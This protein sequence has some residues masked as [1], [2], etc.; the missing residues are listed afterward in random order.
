MPVN[1]TLTPREA[2]CIANNSYFT[3]EGWIKA[4]PSIGVEQWPVVKDAVLGS[5]ASTQTYNGAPANTSLRQTGLK[6]ANLQRVFTATTGAGT[7]TGF[8]YVLRFTQG[9]RKHVVIATRGTRAEIGPADLLTDAYAALTGF[10]DYGVVH[11]GFM[12]TFTSV[13]AGLA[14]DSKL[15]LDADV[16]HCVGHSLGGAVATLVAAHYRTVGQT[17]KLYTFGSPRVGAYGAYAA[18]QQRIGKENI[19]RVSHDL[20]PIS[21][22]GP[23]PYIHV[24]PA[25]TDEN[26]MTLVSP[27]GKLLSVANH[28]MLEYLNS[29]GSSA[30]SWQYVRAQ[31]G[32]VDH[33]NTVLGRWLL[34]NE[35]DRT[36]LRRGAAYALGLLLKLFANEMK[37][38]AN[39]AVLSLTA[40]DMMAELIA[41]GMARIQAISP[42]VFGLM[43]DFAQFAGVAMKAGAE[44]T[45]AI[46][47]RILQTML[48]TLM[49]IA[50]TAAIQAGRGLLPLPLVIAGASALAG[51]VIN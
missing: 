17:V 24:N 22:V 35:A 32:R 37:A 10:G 43:R 18:M 31:T 12:N 40:I 21:L 27:T 50:R 47:R 14:R 15:I 33:D 29:V 39:A 45:V 19:F 30:D 38:S 28:N 48:S 51:T 42:Q 6:D 36:W 25:F 23:F 2:A 34:H 1:D 4:T 20:D 9:G 46:I 11:K 41:S 13:M 7:R 5:G 26:N 8:G 3:L 44:F 16:V 49:P